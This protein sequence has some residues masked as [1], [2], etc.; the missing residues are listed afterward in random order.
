MSED[1]RQLRA[2]LRQAAKAS[3][4]SARHIERAVGLGN[5]CLERVLDG[6]NELRL[7]HLLGFAKLLNVP[8]QDFLELGIPQPEAGTKYRLRDWVGPREFGPPNAAKTNGASEDRG[9]LLNDPDF[10][11]AIRA[12]LREEL[13]KE[14]KPAR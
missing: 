10:K 8:P 7:H 4:L 2:L 12:V 3:G 13:D 6:R 1:I 11:E 14:R 5:G 9:R